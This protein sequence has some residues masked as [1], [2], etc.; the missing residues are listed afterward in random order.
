MD[1]GVYFGVFLI[2]LDSKIVADRPAYDQL[3]DEQIF[4]P[5]ANPDTPP[6]QA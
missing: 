2:G 5:V 4:V 6:T 1:R 3:K